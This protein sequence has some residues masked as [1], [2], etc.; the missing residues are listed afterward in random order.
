MPVRHGALGI[1]VLAERRA[2]Q[3]RL[4]VMRREGVPRKQSMDKAMLDERLHGEAAVMVKGAGR[5]HH[6]QDIA[7]LPFMPKQGVQTVVILGKRRLARTTRAERELIR[8]RLVRF[9]EAV[10]V[11]KHALVSVLAAAER[12]AV[13]R[14]Q[15]P[16]L[17]NIQH[18][19]ISEHNGAVHAAF[20]RK[21]PLPV[22]LDILRVHGRAVIA[23]RR[24]AVHIADRKG[25]VRC[26]RKAFFRKIGR[27]VNGH[28]KF[29]LLHVTSISQ[30]D[31][32]TALFGR[33]R[34]CYTIKSVVLCGSYLHFYGLP[35]EERRPAWV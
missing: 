32:K 3:S 34:M 23:V 20:L 21:P 10:R 2:E 5:P 7:M 16:L 18:A 14:A 9:M 22:D 8:K 4:K 15:I 17:H 30:F 25:G 12:N 26:V 29:F 11:E 28:N 27:P 19:G 33:K 13:A 35:N 24:Y 31:R 1:D 6:E